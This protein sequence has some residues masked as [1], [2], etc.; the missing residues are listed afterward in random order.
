M[1]IRVAVDIGGTFTDL[2]SLNEETGE[3]TEEKA[4]TTP[5]NYAR[6]V[7]NSIDQSGLSLEEASYF[8]HGTTVVINA[9]TEK[10]G[11]KT[12]LITTRGFRDVLEIGR[13]RRPDMY[14]YYFSKPEPFVRRAF[15]FEVTERLNNEGEVVTP[16]AEEELE[17][18]MKTCRDEGVEALAV[19]FLHSYANPEHEKRCQEIIQ[20]KLPGISITISSDLIRE[21][22]EFERT[23]TTVLN[24]YVQPVTGSYLNTL[25]DELDNIGLKINPHAMQSNGGSAT[26]SMARKTPINLVESGPVGGVIAGKVLGDII[27]EENVITFDIGGTTAKTSLISRGEL[28][29]TKDYKVEETPRFPGYP[30][31]LPV[32]DIIEIGNGGGSIAWVDDVGSLQVG[33]ESAGAE[34]GPACYN[35]GG[36]QPT[37]TDANLVAGRINP[38]NFLGGDFE[39]SLEQAHK[40]LEEIASEFNISIKEAALGIIKRANSNMMNALKLISVRRGYDPREFVM[41]GQGGNGAVMGPE[42]GKE[43]RVNK[44]IIP[45]RPA[46]FSAFG[47]LMTDL[48]QD[49]IQTQIMSLA[50][51]DLAKINSIY[52][53]LENE[54]RDVY[55]QQG[56]KDQDLLFIRSADIRYT[57]QEHTVQT[58]VE[59]GKITDQELKSIREKFDQLHHNYYTFNLPESQAEFVNLNLTAYATVSKPELSR[60]SDD[61]SLEK[62]YSGTR[63]I[64]FNEF[65]AQESKVYQRQHLPV[66][67]SING[68][69]AVEESKSVTIIDPEQKLEVDQYGNLIITSRSD[70]R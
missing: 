56:I 21:L 8:V 22:R 42:L 68:P 27:G 69:L 26:F 47:M 28:K 33:P 30:I 37:L 57:G 49:R 61:G 9:L 35:Q 60:A 4:H 45:P 16:L 44:I 46:T 1:A 39:V 63:A 19:C 38:D 31:K 7:L 43:L 65:G 10:K 3:I 62:A 52:Q 64:L 50:D 51:C 32:V 41:V 34:P 40:S 11:A 59:S 67:T 66:A 2:V 20:E 53:Q 36:M 54:A 55:F 29:V 70:I 12:A 15:R 58:P 14:N 18:I 17:D 48:R 6:G 25:E 13:S 24:A 23:S 5:R